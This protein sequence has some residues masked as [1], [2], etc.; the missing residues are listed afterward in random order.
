MEETPEYYENEAIKF[1]ADSC[2]EKDRKIKILSN[3][4]VISVSIN[5]ICIIYGVLC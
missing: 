4:L 2:K 5:L 1:L 3:S